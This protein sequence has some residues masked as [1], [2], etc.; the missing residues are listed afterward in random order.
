MVVG[1]ITIF[2]KYLPK[3]IRGNMGK[4]DWL[5]LLVD[6]ITVYLLS[7][8]CDVLRKLERKIKQIR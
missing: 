7:L 2:V 4:K 5:N 6:I 3:M 8:L 1:V